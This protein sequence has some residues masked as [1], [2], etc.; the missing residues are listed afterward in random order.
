MNHTSGILLFLSFLLSF[1]L[2]AQNNEIKNYDHVYV[3]NI[4]SVKFHIDGLFLSYPIIELNSTN[5]LRLSFDD[6]DADNKNYVYSFIHCNRDWQPS[7]LTEMEYLDGFSEEQIQDFR[8]SFKTIKPF[9]HYEILLPNNYVKWT[10]SGN[11]LL[12]VY[13]NSNQKRPVITRRFMVVESRVKISPQM[14]R[15]A[16]VSKAR[17]HQEIDFIVDHDKFPLRN[18]RQEIRAVI[19]QNGRW[20]NAIEEVEPLFLR[21]NR[22]LF[23]YQDKIVFP[24]G[25]EFRTLDMRSLRYISQ[26]ISSIERMDDIFEVTLYKDRKRNGQPFLSRQDLNGNF[27]IESLDENNF[28]L[29]SDYA[30]VLFILYSPQPLYDQEVFVV[31]NFTDWEMKASNKMVYNDIVNGYVAKIPLKQGFYDY[32]YG[33]KPLND[34]NAYSPNLEE[35]EGDWHETDN[36]YTILIYYKPFGERFD[37]LVGAVTFRSFQ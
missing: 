15:P 1:S 7:Q 20:D 16:K 11:Y 37:R 27:V 19:L 2:S 32:A 34:D 30:N 28:E 24:A 35:I 26:N 5:Q 8:F 12:V 3:D 21:T 14:V 36:Q 22:M 17:T 10:K 23:D 13:D 31:G 25:N 4:Q 6:L 29:S 18:P 33:V 9:T